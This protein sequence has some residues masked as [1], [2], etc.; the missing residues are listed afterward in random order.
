MKTRGRVGADQE[1][2]EKRFQDYVS[3]EISRPQR[4]FAWHEWPGL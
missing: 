3:G 1:F 4:I 2:E